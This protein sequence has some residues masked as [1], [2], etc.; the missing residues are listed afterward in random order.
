MFLLEPIRVLFALCESICLFF[1]VWIV[2]GKRTR[3]GDYFAKL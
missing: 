2:N 3:P 1:A